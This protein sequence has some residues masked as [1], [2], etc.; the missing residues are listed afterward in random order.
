MEAPA[1][2]RLGWEDSMGTN[3]LKKEQKFYVNFFFMV[4][5][6][7]RVFVKFVQP[8]LAFSSKAMILT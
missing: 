6:I 1:N 2:M 7:F 8:T 5:Y 4:Q 3:T